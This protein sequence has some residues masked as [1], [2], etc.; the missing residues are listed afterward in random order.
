MRLWSSAAIVLSALEIFSAFLGV[1]AL[2]RRVP[3]GF[4]TTDG[5]QFV[6]DGKPL[7][8]RSLSFSLT[9]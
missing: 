7:V 8:S 9:L 2:P 5:A 4:A 6:V 3:R 1:S